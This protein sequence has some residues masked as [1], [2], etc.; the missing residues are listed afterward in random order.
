[1]KISDL[2]KI[3]G[4][5]VITIEPN[6]TVS[7]AIQK[8]A[9]NNRGSLPVCN[10]KGELVGIVTERDILKPNPTQ[11]CSPKHSVMEHSPIFLSIIQRDYWPASQNVFLI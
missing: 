7:T 11:K 4:R 5:L 8:L 3:K 10:E 2:L 1:M 6:E 9:E